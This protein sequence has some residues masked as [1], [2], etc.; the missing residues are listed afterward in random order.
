MSKTLPQSL[1]GAVGGKAIIIFRDIDGSVYHGR[2]TQAGEGNR[3]CFVG[4][5]QKDGSEIARWVDG[6]QL[7]I[8]A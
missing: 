5:S 7:S 8:P 6:S 2:I 3:F 1:R 4:R